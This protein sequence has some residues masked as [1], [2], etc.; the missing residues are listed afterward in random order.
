LY[1]YEAKFGAE[2]G[3]MK[4]KYEAAEERAKKAKLGLWRQKAKNRVSPAEFKRAIR[5]RQSS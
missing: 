3:G 5:Q 4:V 2:F 1:S